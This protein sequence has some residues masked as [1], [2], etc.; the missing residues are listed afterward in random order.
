[1]QAEPR[2]RFPYA[3]PQL[4]ADAGR[5][6]EADKEPRGERNPTTCCHWVGPILL[7]LC[8]GCAGFHAAI[9]GGWAGALRGRIL[10]ECAEA[11]RQQRA[12]LWLFC[13]AGSSPE[14]EHYDCLWECI[15]QF[16]P[17]RRCF[18]FD[19]PASKRDLPRLEELPDDR[20]DPEFLQ[21]LEEFCSYIWLSS[22]PKTIP[23]VCKVCGES[24]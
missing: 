3:A 8:V 24:E 20:M 14:A 6:R 7:N 16:F 17:E 18:I 9:G 5:V 2:S 15:R 19:Q 1:M 21:Q 22:P 10:G 13:P 4:R 11:G 23:S 12:E